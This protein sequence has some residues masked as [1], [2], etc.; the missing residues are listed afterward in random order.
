[1]RYIKGPA[2]KSLFH[3]HLTERDNKKFIVI[4]DD[5]IGMSVTNNIENIIDWIAQEENIDPHEFLIVY[6]DSEGIF[7]GFDYNTLNFVVLS[8]S[9]EEDAI[10]LYLQKSEYGIPT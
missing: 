7:D 5:D 3:Y 10:I 4:Y 9:S 1:M 6:K 8:E 2:A